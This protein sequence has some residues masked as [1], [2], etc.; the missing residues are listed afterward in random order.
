MRSIDAALNAPRPSAQPGCNEFAAQLSE[1]VLER[2]E[3]KWFP[4][5][6]ELVRTQI[7]EN[8]A[9]VDALLAVQRHNTDSFWGLFRDQDGARELVG[10]YGQLLLN[11]DG[12]HALKEGI[13]DR[14]D[15]QHALLTGPGERPD[16]IYIWCIVAKKKLAALQAALLDRLPH[17]AGVPHYTCLATADSY[18]VGRRLGFVPVSASDDRMGGIFR[19]PA[20]M[21]RM[22]KQQDATSVKVVETFDELEQAK[23]LRAIIFVGEQHCPYAEEFDGND[24]SAQHVIGFVNGEPAAT[25]RIRHFAGFVKWERFCV[26]PQFRKTSVKSELIEFAFGLAKQKGF[27]RVYFQAEPR[28]AHFWKQHGFTQI[29]NDRTVRFSDREYLEFER[30]VLSNEMPIT[31]DS[32]PMVLNR[33]EGAWSSPGVLD[34][35]AIRFTAQQGI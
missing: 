11:R 25:M 28:L 31:L 3:P 5:L 7:S 8:T 9:T 32:D 19:A 13:L 1:P 30:D 2:L 14:L 16:A 10:I 26:L 29:A 4:K 35:S 23:A 17:L 27:P 34:R 12:H 33:A 15:P 20:V 21:P 6:A 18:S 22:R 24:A